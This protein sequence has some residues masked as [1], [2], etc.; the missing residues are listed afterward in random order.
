MLCV[1]LL[2]AV[3][4]I[5]QT[6]LH[7]K[8]TPI[9]LPTATGTIEGTLCLPETP[10]PMPVALIV[11][12]SGPTDRN[13]NNAMMINNSLKML[14]DSLAFHGIASVR[15]DKRG[16][17]ASKSALKSEMDIRFEDYVNDAE[18]W[19]QLL[20]KDSR[21][22]KSIVIGHS[23]GALIGMIASKYNADALVLIAGAG[24]SAGKLLKEQLANQPEVIRNWIYADIDTLEMGKTLQYV[25]PLLY[26]LFRPSVQPYLISWFKYHPAK[27]IQQLGNKPVCIIQGTNDIQVDTADAIL[28]AKADTAATLVM[29]PD[30]N[31]IFKIVSGDRNANIATYNNPQ[32]PI[33]AQL[34]STIVNFIHAL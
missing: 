14:A 6:S 10:I 12:G 18:Q 8:E 22:S 7:F 33:S 31:H 13:G 30:M 28:L 25:H 21:F 27:V 15:Y 26:N 5:A 11:A 2:I 20:K 19:I 9:A 24:R 4:V 34:V 17:G 32:L 16:I 23:E 1:G 3:I 29:I